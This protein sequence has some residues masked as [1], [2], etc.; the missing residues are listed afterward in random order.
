MT[1]SIHQTSMLWALSWHDMQ[2][3]WKRLTQSGCYLLK[4]VLAPQ[5]LSVWAGNMMG[6]GEQG[7]PGLSKASLVQGF[8]ICAHEAG[9]PPSHDSCM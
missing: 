7:C 4:L 9:R 8:L 2:V 1:E 6:H 5:K 3:S